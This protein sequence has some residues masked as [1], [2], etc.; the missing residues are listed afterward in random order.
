M[1]ELVEHDRR[2]VVEAECMAVLEAERAGSLEEFGVQVERLGLH[3]PADRL[4]PE[5]RQVVVRDWW[6]LLGH[7]P[8]DIVAAAADDALLK[9]PRFRPTLGEFAAIAEPMWKWRQALAR[10]AADTL[11]AIG[12]HG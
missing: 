12:G 11:R 5:E 3:Y 10:R 7:L 6:R 9:H 4:E 2:D 8:P 1:R